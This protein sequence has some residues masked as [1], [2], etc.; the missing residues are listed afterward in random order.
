[1]NYD[2]LLPYQC[3][4]ARTLMR[5]LQK[6]VA[7]DTSDVGTGKMHVGSVLVREL[8]DRP[9]VVVCPKIITGAWEETAAAKGCGVTTINY[10]LVRTGTTTLGGWRKGPNGKPYFNWARGIDTVIFDEV[11]RAGSPSS[12]NAQIVAGARL[13]RKRILAMSATPAVSPLGMRALGYVAGL[14]K[15]TDFYPWA[16]DYN[17]RNVITQGWKFFGGRAEMKRIHEQLM[18][19]GSRMRVE[20]LIAKGLFP[21]SRLLPCTYTIDQPA[22]AEKLYAEMAEQLRLLYDRKKQDKDPTAIQ[23]ELLR[24]REEIELLKVPVLVEL[25]KDAVAEGYS[26]P[27]FVHFRST[28]KA[29]LE[30]LAEFNPGFI[31]GGQPSAQRRQFIDDFQHGLSRVIV[32]IGAAG[33]LGIGLHNVHGNYPRQSLICLDWSVTTLEQILGRIHRA[34]S[35]TPALQ[36]IVLLN[37]PSERRIKKAIETKG[38]NARTLVDADLA[39]ATF[40]GKFVDSDIPLA[41]RCA[42]INEH[43]D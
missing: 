21:E 13:C 3:D 32:C 20:E 34:G 15:W 16:R 19:V 35:K 12:Q 25:C 24:V 23:T 40:F 8:G 39:P 4:H 41:L 37:T 6:G 7:V 38:C 31:W 22:T 9:T 43:D 28:V 33:G 36:R 5:H 26:V 27:I 42:P 14:H 10:E 30:K 2:G 11:H 18:R 29:L 1:M 17:C